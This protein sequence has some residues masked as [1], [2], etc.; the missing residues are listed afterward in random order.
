MHLTAETVKNAGDI[1]LFLRP[2]FHQ[3]HKDILDIL[4]SLS[5]NRKEMGTSILYLVD[6]HLHSKVHRVIAL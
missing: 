6:F 3:V 4:E 2:F 5:L 1:I